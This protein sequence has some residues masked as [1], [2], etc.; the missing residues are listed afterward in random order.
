MQISRHFTSGLTKV[1]EKKFQDAIQDFSVAIEEEPSFV[2]AYAER[3][4]A[5]IQLEENELA[6][7]DLNVCVE[8]EPNNSY[9]YSCRAFLK[10]RIGDLDGALLDYEKAIHLD[11]DDAIAYNN[12]GLVQEQKGYQKDAQQSFEKSNQIIGY[13][14]NRFDEAD[15]SKKNKTKAVSDDTPEHE[16]GMKIARSVFTKK[17]SFREFIS[18]IGNGFKLKNNDKS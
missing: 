2:D 3:A 9:R 1:Q 6:M 14:P 10:A 13:K 7:F 12:M 16:S 17:S 11:P 8:L 4:V 15:P 18:F 5:Y